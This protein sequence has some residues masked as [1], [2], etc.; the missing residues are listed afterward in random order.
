MKLTDELK[1]KIKDAIE[2]G[3]D[4]DYGYNGEDEYRID[5]FETE[6]ALNAVIRV[7]K[8]EKLIEE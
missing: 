8:E 4:V 3:K 2:S 1:E 5:I 6:T 7:L